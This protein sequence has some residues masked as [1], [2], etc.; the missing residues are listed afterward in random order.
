MIRHIL[1]SRM[2]PGGCAVVGEIS[3]FIVFANTADELGRAKTEMW[4]LRLT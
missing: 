4:N 3:M 1:A 2:A